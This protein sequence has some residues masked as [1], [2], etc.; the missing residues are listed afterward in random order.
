MP[1]KLLHH[2]ENRMAVMVCV[3]PVLLPHLIFQGSRGNKCR[4]PAPPVLYVPPL[5]ENRGFRF[6][7]VCPLSADVY[8]WR[9][10]HYDHGLQ[11]LACT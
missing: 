3:V 9:V 8:R 4:P 11:L 5:F 7:S 6:P 10:D 2:L 1:Q